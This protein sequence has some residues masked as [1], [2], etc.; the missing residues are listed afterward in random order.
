MSIY[1][2]VCFAK[3][4][5][6]TIFWAQIPNIFG[7]SIPNKFDVQMVPRLSSY[8][9]PIFYLK[10][11]VFLYHQS[12]TG[13]I[14]IGLVCFVY[15]FGYIRDEYFSEFDYGLNPEYFSEYFLMPEYIRSGIYSG[16]TST[17]AFFRVQNL[18]SIL[19]LK[20]AKTAQFCKAKRALN[21]RGH[22]GTKQNIFG[23][24]SGFCVDSLD[25][26]YRQEL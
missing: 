8:F 18:R 23:T 14:G 7:A 16:F 13:I 26:T 5:T 15:L 12:R 3:P 1:C 21:K 17:W 20:Y 22:T 6:F 9:I 10:M 4:S 25:Q 19:H 24:D 2:Y 11:W